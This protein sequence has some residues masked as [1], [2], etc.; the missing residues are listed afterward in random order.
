MSRWKTRQERRRRMRD[1]RI[2]KRKQNQKGSLNG[3]RPV[4]ATLFD[5][6]WKNVIRRGASK[7]EI[8]VQRR[9]FYAGAGAIFSGI[10]GIIDGGREVTEDDVAVLDSIKT[11]ISDFGESA[12]LEIGSFRRGNE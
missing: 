8:L 11:E 4:I 5:S 10:M 9:A 1:R 7:R 3:D 2:L 6:Y 12:G